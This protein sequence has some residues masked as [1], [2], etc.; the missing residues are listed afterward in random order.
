MEWNCKDTKVAQSDKIYFKLC[1]EYNI[2]HNTNFDVNDF[3][4]LI[5][6]NKDFRINW[7]KYKENKLINFI[8]KA[9]K[10]IKNKGISVSAAIL[11]NY[12]NASRMY[13]QDYKKWASLGIVDSFEVM[14]YQSN[15]DNFS[16][17]KFLYRNHNIFH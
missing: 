1:N 9:S 11:S 5:I 10:I 8:T 14:N 2:N 3:R 12:Q 7:L 15:I 13:L 4:N 17:N 6:N 16:L